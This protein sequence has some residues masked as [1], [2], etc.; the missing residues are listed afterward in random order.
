[1]EVDVQSDGMEV[2]D[3]GFGRRTG[4]PLGET[5]AEVD[6]MCERDALVIDVDESFASDSLSEASS[7]CK[8]WNPDGPMAWQRGEVGDLLRIVDDDVRDM[9]AGG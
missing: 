7:R 8:S 3:E 6:L 1:M 9:R 4:D 5:G 2:V